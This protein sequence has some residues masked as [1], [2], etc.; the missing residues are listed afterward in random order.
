MVEDEPTQRH[1]L[2]DYLA[3][4]GFKAIGAT[5]GAALRRTLQREEL[6]LVL[7]DVGLPGRTA[8]ASPA[9]C[10]NIIHVSAS[11]WSLRQATR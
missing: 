2:V 8:S 3:R 11:S 10:A 4:Q 7:L 5:D 9:T 1:L 6:A